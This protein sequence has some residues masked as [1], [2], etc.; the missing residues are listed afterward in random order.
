MAQYGLIAFRYGSAAPAQLSR[1][2]VGFYDWVVRE[3]DEARPSL[4]AVQASLPLTL[5]F[6]HAEYLESAHNAYSK[7]HKYVDHW[8][9]GIDTIVVDLLFHYVSRPIRIDIA[10]ALALQTIFEESTGT[11]KRL[12]LL[13]GNAPADKTYFG[14]ILS[15][16]PK[17]VLQV[18]ALDALDLHADVDSNFALEFRQRYKEV[19]P[20]PIRRLQQKLVAK[21]GH[22]RSD[23]DVCIKLAFD[24]SNAEAE[25]ADLFIDVLQRLGNTA[26]SALLFHSISSVWLDQPI[27]VAAAQLGLTATQWKESKIGAAINSGTT[28][29]ILVVPLYD[30][31]HT[32]QRILRDVRSTGYKGPFHVVAALSTSGNAGDFGLFEQTLASETIGIRYLLKVGEVRDQGECVQCKLR[33]R[34]TVWDFAYEEIESFHFWAMADDWRD[35]PDKERPSSR[36]PAGY[37]PNFSKVAESNG[38]WLAQKFLALIAKVSEVDV[39]A[40]PVIVVCLEED[41]ARTL[42]HYVGVLQ[43][44]TV[45]AIP[46]PDLD[47]FVEPTE[48]QKGLLNGKVWAERIDQ[49]APTTRIILLEEYIFS[50]KTKELLR[51]ALANLTRKRTADFHVAIVDF[52]NPSARAADKIKTLSL[53]ACPLS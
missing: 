38:A 21:R 32:A 37:L 12:I 6:T 15:S 19:S 23:N 52:R 36:A 5:A 1:E 30:T 10:L 31:G 28:Q 4:N 7:L 2:L 16:F 42:A 20:E 45:V 40:D 46:R 27:R 13:V 48:G 11:L 43:G 49:A 41:G 17:H 53:Y 50:G 8:I 25:L 33:K 35:E 34:H 18:V 3:L 47:V 39:R 14:K 22:F 51:R 44:F 29:V 9:S 24:G 26:G